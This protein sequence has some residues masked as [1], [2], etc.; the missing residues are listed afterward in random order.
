MTKCPWSRN[1]P[2]SRAQGGGTPVGN[3]SFVNQGHCSDSWKPWAQVTLTL[4]REGDFRLP[5]LLL[6]LPLSLAPR[7]LFAME[8]WELG[9]R[10]SGALL[11]HL[12]SV[13]S[14]LLSYYV[15]HCSL[16]ETLPS[17]QT[18]PSAACLQA[19]AKA[20]HTSACHTLALPNSP[21]L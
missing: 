4:G 10:E 11:W 15:L 21:Q 12:K 17:S 2:G 1:L 14:Y 13:G 6:L 8:S 9:L 16:L 19:F 5:P 7:S 3:I 18:L 20:V